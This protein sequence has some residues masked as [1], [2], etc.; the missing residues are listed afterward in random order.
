MLV[1]IG[2]KMPNPLERLFP[3][4]RNLLVP[5]WPNTFADRGL[6]ILFTGRCGSTELV[7]SIS[8]TGL[9]GEPDEYFNEET[10]PETAKDWQCTSIDSYVAKLIETKSINRTFCFK[11]D[12]FRLRAL[13]AMISPTRFF[14]KTNF[15]YL[16]M[17]RRNV[18]E[19]AL[20]YALAKRSGKWHSLA[21]QE[22]SSQSTDDC[23]LLTDLEIWQEIA[24]VLD[25]EFHIEN[26]I[27]ESAIN[28]IRIDYEMFCSNRWAV[29]ADV[30]LH[31]GCQLEEV[32]QA[33]QNARETYQRNHYDASKYSRIH[34]FKTRYREL[35]THLLLR[36][37]AIPYA[38]VDNF[39]RNQLG[40]DIKESN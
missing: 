17:N 22:R 2:E 11:I 35:L 5:E 20:S 24:L 8:A 19:Q 30:L 33:M 13:K 6:M 36:R 4:S 9:C 18:L 40:I 21:G 28:V 32:Q 37:G 1:D 16:Y 26:H 27:V 29:L 3:G 23:S 38:S 15:N 31:S 25:Q 39:L 7:A 34:A 12:G 14:P 10:I